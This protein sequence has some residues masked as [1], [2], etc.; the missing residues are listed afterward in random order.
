MPVGR[1]TSG[2]TASDEAFDCMRNWIREC[3]NEHDFC[4]AP[5]AKPLPTR[6]VDVGLANGKM[7]LIETSGESGLYVALS[8]CWGKEQIITTTK[9]S[10][11]RL[12]DGIKFEE[13]SETFYQAI[14]LTRRLEMNYIW[15][16]SLCIVQDDKEDWAREASKMASFYENAVLTVAA[17][18]SSSG[19]GG[20]FRKK[21]DFHLSGS[22]AYGEPYQLIFRERI[23]HEMMD[24]ADERLRKAFPLMNRAWVL[25]ERL[26]SSR[27][28]HFGP[29]ELFFECRTSSECEC[30]EIDGYEVANP[31][32]KLMY[33]ESLNS[34]DNA[35]YIARAWHGLIGL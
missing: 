29:H 18:S 21:P 25:Q 32:P 14:Q 17:T 20:L 15:I 19:N 12:K 11:A 1:R 33:A 6:L 9:A 24:S 16:D 31:N 35:W 7:R 28:I 30:G 13:C 4:S 26:L 22:T 27:V 34:S 3:S 8:H 2:N 5:S 23:D 10:L